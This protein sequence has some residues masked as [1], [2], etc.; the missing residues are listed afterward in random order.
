[1]WLGILLSVLAIGIGL[2]IGIPRG[3]K[4]KQLREDGRIVVRNYRYAEKGEEFTSRIGSFAALKDALVKADI[5]CNM[6]GNLRSQVIFQ[7]SSFAARLYSVAFDEPS[8]I[9]IFRFE[10]TH[11]RTGR[12]GY[13]EDTSMNMLMTSIEKV[14][15]SLDPNTGVKSYSIDFKTRHSIL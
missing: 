7:S 6:D 14:F 2:A 12:Y 11:W 9:G 5:P 3:K 1:M 4:I 13:E 8:G 15:L 10:F